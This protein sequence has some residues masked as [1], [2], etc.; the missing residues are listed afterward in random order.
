MDLERWRQIEQIYYDVL[1]APPDGRNLLLD[2]AC[3][4]DPE[5]RREVESL[6]RSDSHA[7]DFLSSRKLRDHIARIGS[8]ADVG[9]VG[10][11]VGPYRILS[12]IGAGAM[13]E[14][15]LARDMRLDRQVALKV[16]PTRFTDDPGRVARFVREAK[17]ASAL[18]H[19]NIITIHEIGQTGRTWFIAAEF[20]QGVTLRERL[21]DGPLALAD[22]VDIA[23]Q[24]AVA[25]DVANQA[26]ILHRDIKPEN[27]MIRADGLVKVVDFGLARMSEAPHEGGPGD[28]QAGLVMGTPRYM[29]PEQARGE[30]IDERSDIFSLGSV[31][32]EM[33]TGRP[34]FPGNTVADVFAALLGPISPLGECAPE[35]LEKTVLKALEKDRKRRYQSMKELAQ[36]LDDCKEV[37]RSGGVAIRTAPGKPSGLRRRFIAGGAAVILLGGAFFAI[38]RLSLYSRFFNP[39]GPSQNSLNVV[40]VTSSPGPKRLPAFSPDGNR[41]AYSSDANSN[42]EWGRRPFHIYVKEVGG[43]EA[44][45]LTFD[46]A[47]S[48]LAVSWSPDGNQIAFC[49]SL[50][51]I[52]G[53]HIYV[54][55]VNGGVARK[56]AESNNLGVSWSADGQTL[57]LAGKP[58]RASPAAEEAGGIFL[59]SLQTGRTRE[60]TSSPQDFRPE[61]SPDG[62]WVAFSRPL[63]FNAS[64]LFVISSAGGQARQLTTDSALIAGGAWTPDSRE[65]VL[66]STRKGVGLWSV[67]IS[68]AHPRP[69]LLN[70]RGLSYPTVARH[71]GRL[72]YTDFL[73]DSNLYLLAGAGFQRG[74]VPAPFGK[75]LAVVVSSRPDHSPDISADGSRFVFV[76]G[77]SGNEEIWISP[78]EGGQPSQLTSLGSPN[79]GTPRWSPDGRRVTFDAYVSGKPQVFVIDARGGVPRQITT[80]PSGGFVPAWSHDGQRIYFNSQRSGRAEIWKVPAAGGPVEQVTHAGAFEAHAAP[81]GSLVYFTKPDSTGNFTIWSIPAAGGPETPVAEL[82]RFSG[83]ERSW[84]VLKEGI[85]F[86]ER[87]EQPRQVAR[88]FSF[89]SHQVTQLFTKEKASVRDVPNIALSED[90]RYALFVQ[91]DQR[92]NDL[93]MISNFR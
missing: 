45:Q 68:G 72:A 49:R 13:G 1:E 88:F 60:L 56:V 53:N 37:A 89:R 19:P 81:D 38:P 71:V 55:P 26:G 9:M 34:A 15:Y 4:S 17:A 33:V 41:I 90:G 76:S 12:A 85:Y 44:K 35:A 47:G 93:V 39:D 91:V 69:V 42:A 10:S 7:G 16:L 61:F 65:V 66:M 27:I 28:T 54:M 23:M 31:L 51:G 86:L 59:L 84:G 62:R 79:I 5:L 36:A 32:Y 50:P 21:A 6:L 73:V 8:P 64:E 74:S 70:L 18:N 14:V 92:I 2:S 30:P 87:S 29:S 58:K 80:E 40:P 75:P 48:D 67:P 43:G 78:R 24:C 82:Q 63:S 22:S 25:L 20:I 77:R 83:I 3:G 57:A 46:P 52:P 11:E